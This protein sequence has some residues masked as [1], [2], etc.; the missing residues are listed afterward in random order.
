MALLFQG[1]AVM[2]VKQR[3]QNKS[4]NE[5]QQ[6]LMWLRRRASQEEVEQENT[7]KQNPVVIFSSI[8]NVDVHMQWPKTPWINLPKEINKV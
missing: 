4:L 5:M 2:A 6:L 1:V 8:L 3:E 7:V